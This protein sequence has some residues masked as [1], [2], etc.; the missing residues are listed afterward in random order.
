MTALGLLAAV[1]TSVAHEWV[2][3]GGM[4]LANG[5]EATLLTSMIFRC[6]GGGAVTDLAGP[7][8]GLTCGLAAFALIKLERSATFRLFLL[9]TGAIALFWYFGQLAQSAAV[10]TGDWAFAAQALGWP[11]FWRPVAVVLGVGGYLLTV[12]LATREA[13]VL[14]GGPGA[15]WRLRVPYL[16]A[17]VAA[18]IAGALWDKDRV[19]SVWENLLAVGIAPLG[20]LWAVRV[21]LRTPSGEA[22]I[23]RSWPWIVVSAALFTAFCLTAGLGLGRLA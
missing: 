5:G 22:A 12:A 16:A 13:R 19:G 9:M 6:Q 8:G 21:A 3:H 7:L 11:G 18:V 1:V 10:N 2:G 14:A 23:P 17:V 4:C 20:Y 15:A